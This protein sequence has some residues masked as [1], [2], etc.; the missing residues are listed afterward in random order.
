MVIV[1]AQHPHR[2]EFI[3]NELSTLSIGVGYSSLHERFSPSIQQEFNIRYTAT[4][5]Q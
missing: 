3:S 4:K 1:P 5:V 2:I